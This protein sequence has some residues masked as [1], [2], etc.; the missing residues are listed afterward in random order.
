MNRPTGYKIFGI[1]LITALALSGCGFWGGLGASP[2]P[3]LPSATEAPVAP[4][5]SPIPSGTL[6]VGAPMPASLHPLSVRLPEWI[7][8]YKLLFPSLYILDGGLDAIPSLVDS[9]TQADDLHWSLK[10][11]RKY[12]WQD[13]NPVTAQDAAATIA[14]MLP[15]RN[16]I[17][18]MDSPWNFSAGLIESAIA[19]E[20]DPYRLDITL[21]HPAGYLPWLLTFP[22]LPAHIFGAGPDMSSITLAAQSLIGCGPY[23]VSA[24]ESTDSVLVCRRAGGV[25]REPGIAR[26]EMTTVTG[27]TEG[28]QML[29]DGALDLVNIPPNN[30]VGEMGEEKIVLYPYYTGE[31]QFIVFSPTIR[32]PGEDAILQAVT[33]ALDRKQIMNAVYFGNA[34]LVDSPLRPDTWLFDPEYQWYEYDP[35]RADEILIQAGWAD[36]DEDG[37]REYAEA[38]TEPVPPTPLPT[39]EPADGAE[40]T[41]APTPDLTLDNCTISLLVDEGNDLNRQAAKSV[42]DQLK[43]IGVE[44]AVTILPWEDGRDHTGY[45]ERVQMGQYDMALATAYIQSLPIPDEL[46]VYWPGVADIPADAL[47]NDWKRDLPPAGRFP[48]TDDAVQQRLDTVAQASGLEE[49]GDIYQQMDLDGVWQSLS[50]SLFYRLGHLGA[51][52]KVMGIESARQTDLFMGIG[53]WYLTK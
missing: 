28:L 16:G 24:D 2:Q 23:R 38:W 41:P 40:E 9:V 52:P 50:Y 3:T 48:Y 44:V 6:R 5:G 26:I 15:G 25:D 30:Y 47:W 8:L 27:Y 45:L 18:P 51:S 20:D 32:L 53:N 29:Q 11:S 1:L 34:A 39:E 21:Y 13:G 12:T 4:P 43:K 37:Y 31:Y 14:M 42:R 19:A 17:Y 10:L 7:S 35:D 46:F 49:I 33:Y 36:M 22:I